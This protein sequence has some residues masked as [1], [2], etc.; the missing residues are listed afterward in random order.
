[1][2][3]VTYQDGLQTRYVYNTSKRLLTRAWNHDGYCM[4]GRY[5]IYLRLLY[6]LIIYVILLG[7][8]NNK[9][10]E[11]WSHI[12]IKDYFSLYFSVAFLY[13]FSLWDDS[14]KLWTSE[15]WRAK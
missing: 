6:L 7:Q 13:V 10:A 4:D 14:I 12:G 5:P 3:T 11:R 2:T 9:C 8:L 1:M 15:A